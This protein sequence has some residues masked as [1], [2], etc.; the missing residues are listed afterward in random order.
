M[1]FADS[2]N[3]IVAV[4]R[5]HPEL[6]SRLIFYMK[7]PHAMLSTANRK[8]YTSLHG[9]ETVEGMSGGNGCDGFL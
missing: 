1:L 4:Q 3:G 6:F 5:V 8:V 2:I 9:N 7:G